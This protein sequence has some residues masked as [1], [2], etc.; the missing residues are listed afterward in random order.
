MEL[1]KCEWELTD[2]KQTCTK[3]ERELTNVK[4]TCTEREMKLKKELKQ[5]QMELSNYKTILSER[6]KEWEG[7]LN[8]HKT[9]FKNELKEY[10]IYAEELQNSLANTM[11]K[12]DRLESSRSPFYGGK[13]QRHKRYKR[14]TKRQ[15]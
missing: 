4:Q 12:L 14:L 6:E 1:Q 3:C 8:Q 5:N 9:K 7:Q 15:M 13:S 2:V 10:D 11:T